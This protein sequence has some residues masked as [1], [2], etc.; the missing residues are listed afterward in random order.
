MRQGE[1][2]LDGGVVEIRRSEQKGA[3][4][5]SRK[6]RLHKDDEGQP[7]GTKINDVEDE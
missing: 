5:N 1:L 3:Q 4:R 7:D 6:D 2:E